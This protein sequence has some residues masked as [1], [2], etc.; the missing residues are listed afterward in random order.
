MKFDGLIS[1]IKMLGKEREIWL[2]NETFNELGKQKIR[3]SRK[4]NLIIYSD[5]IEIEISLKGELVSNCSTS[6]ARIERVSEVFPN[7]RLIKGDIYISPK[8]SQK[9]S[10]IL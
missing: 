1:T 8:I 5:D 2:T 9:L 4:D 7:T 6:F 3:L 10:L